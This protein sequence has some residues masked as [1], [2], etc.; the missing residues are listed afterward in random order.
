[1]KTTVSAAIITLDEEHN[2]PGLLAALDWVDEI[3]V[4][5]GGSQDRTVEIAR[6]AGVNLCESPFRDYQQQRNLALDAAGGDWVVSIDADERPTPAL[7][8]EILATIRDVRNPYV[9]FRVP[10]RSTILGRPFHFAGTQD[11]RPVRVYRRGSAR[12]VKQVHESVEV[13]GPVGRLENPL[14]HYTLPTIEDFLRKVDHYTTL[15]ADR[16]AAEGRRLWPWE[17]YLRPPAAF[18]RRYIW[19]L[20]MFDGWE[21]LVFSALSG[22]SAWM[23]CKKLGEARREAVQRGGVARA[24]SDRCSL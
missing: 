6:R 5:D 12:W 8:D 11:D 20:G 14:L 3:V 18:V 19:K 24:S 23:K 10:I 4:V 1:M 13:R 15:E 22:F 21:G 2:L 16:L 17:P 9:A 7:R